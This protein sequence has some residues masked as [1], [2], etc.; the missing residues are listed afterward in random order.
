MPH[1]RRYVLTGTPGSGKTTILHEEVY[2]SLG[3]RL[4]DV[5]AAPVS[6]RVDQ[7]VAIVDPSSMTRAGRDSTPGSARGSSA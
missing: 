6:A 2:R 4:V 3:F 1:V 5:P 7:V